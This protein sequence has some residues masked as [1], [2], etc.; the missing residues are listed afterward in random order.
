MTTA[1]VQELLTEEMWESLTDLFGSRF[2]YDSAI[3]LFL[4]EIDEEL[5]YYVRLFYADLDTIVGSTTPADM[6]ARMAFLHIGDAF[7]RIFD[8]LMKDYDPL[9]NFF[10]KG[11]FTK[12]GS[13]E[14]EKTGTEKTTPNGKIKVIQSG[15]AT[16]ETENTFSV[17]Q[18]STFDTATTTPP[19]T[20]DAASDLYNISRNINHA[21]NKQVLGNNGQNFP[22]TTTEYLDHY[23]EKSFTNR[24]DTT[25]YKNYKEGEDKHGN[26]GIFSKQDL[27][28][29]EVKLR[30]RDR[31]IPIY[32]RMVVD[33][34]SSGVWG[35]AES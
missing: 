27:V 3:Y 10:T 33:C 18:G 28:S 5:N 15:E 22:T 4:D 12:S 17:G 25:G 13:I 19:G 14:E 21:K 11:E 8:I 6:A 24:K 23:V 1:K 30:L 29:R 35:S 31:V 26:S 2:G 34:F 32:V 9:E 20:D 16:N 7:K